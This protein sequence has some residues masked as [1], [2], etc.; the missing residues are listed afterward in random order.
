M[1]VTHDSFIGIYENAF[2]AEYC[3]K[4]IAHFNWSAQNS[5]VWDRSETTE[6]FKKDGACALNPT[7]P[8]EIAFTSQN[9]CSLVGE[10]N[11]IF[12]DQC[13]ADYRNTYSVLNDYTRHTV[14]TYK[15][16]KTQ[17]AGGYHVWHCED[18]SVD[19]S[20][21]IGVYILYLNDVEEGGETEFLYCSK[22]I[23]PKKGTLLIFPPN[24]PW[25][26]RGNPPLSGDKYIMTGWIEYA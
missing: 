13:Y 5:R 18:G 20:R 7:N 12:W 25:T 24:Y 19:F 9:L 10:F 23:A 15:V 22:R 2:S 4:I 11:Q 21:R 14:Y 26:H 6:R 1:Q 17:R 8:N 3:D 16:Q